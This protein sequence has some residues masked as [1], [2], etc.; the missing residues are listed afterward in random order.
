MS[1]ITKKISEE[2]RDILYDIYNELEEINLPTTFSSKGIKG[3]HHAVKIGVSN[4]K[5]ARQACFGVVKYQGKYT[6]SKYIKK[7]PEMMYLFEE[8]IDSHLSGFEFNS[9]Y[10]NK[11][12][13]CKWH[14]DS[15]NVSESLL[16][17]LGEYTSGQSVL[18]IKNK[19]IKFNIK[20]QSLLFNGSEI[21]HRSLPFKG[22]RY[23]LVFF[24][25]V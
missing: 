25:T 8:F 17:G 13:V 14:I 23:S 7:Y 24:K 18:K 22:D 6:L 19:E 5:N 16:V 9:V 20:S 2:D 15:K 11:N 21:E 4:Q 12:V 10:V 3:H 1:Y